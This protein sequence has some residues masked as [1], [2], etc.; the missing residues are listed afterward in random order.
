PDDDARR[1]VVWVGEHEG[2]QIVVGMPYNMDDTLGPQ[3]KLTQRFVDA[4]R[5]CATCP[6]HV[7]DERLTSYQAD[8]WLRQRGEKRSKARGAR[9]ALAALAIL[10]N[11]LAT[12]TRRDDDRP[13][14]GG[15]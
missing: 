13:G 9:D 2:D 5:R 11:Y 8:E 12:L 3:A 15:E 4:L 14:D 6:V 1:V 7:C 10:Q